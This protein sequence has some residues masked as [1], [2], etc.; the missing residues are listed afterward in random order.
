MKF[1]CTILFTLLSL[2]LFSQQKKILKGKVYIN[3]TGES[4]SGIY[5]KN[6]N[7]DYTTITDL[8]GNFY[9]PAEKGDAIVF[10]SYNIEK[11]TVIVTFLMQE[12]GIMS[13]QLDVKEKQ[14]DNIY[15]TDFKTYGNIELDVKRIPM[16]NKTNELMAKLGNLY[17][18]MKMDGSTDVATE[19]AKLSTMK[20][21]IDAVFDVLSGD[22]KRRE[23][24]SAYEEQI[25]EIKTIHEYFGDEYFLGLGLE[26]NQIDE[27]ILYTYLNHDVRFYYKHGN[28]FQILNTFDKNI[29]AFKARKENKVI[30]SNPKI[31]ET[32]FPDK[33]E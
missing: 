15:I 23:R 4:V 7:S 3:E 31:G 11:R 18:T 27:F 10:Q 16:M 9:M 8:I 30:S 5:V 20:F 1:I 21:G 29:L 25:K 19:S 28:Y 12:K 13:I 22:N 24:L 32:Y 26:K 14:L 17:P 2:L 33:K 6:L